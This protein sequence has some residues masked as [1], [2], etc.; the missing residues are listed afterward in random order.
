MNPAPRRWRQ[1]DQEVKVVLSHIEEFKV[2]IV[3]DS[4]SQKPK[5]NKDH[6]PEHSVS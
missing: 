1:G 6:V 5:V 3:I 4:L 2:G